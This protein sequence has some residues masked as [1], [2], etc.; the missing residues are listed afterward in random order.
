MSL[1]SGHR[2]TA[3][4]SNTLQL[5]EELIPGTLALHMRPLLDELFAKPF[6][7]TRNPLHSLGRFAPRTT[8]EV[9]RDVAQHRDS[10][11]L[12]VIGG[13]EDEELALVRVQPAALVGGACAVT[14][15]GHAPAL[16]TG[17]VLVQDL[18]HRRDRLSTHTHAHMY[19]H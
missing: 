8:P 3:I 16:Q 19:T 6:E 11:A 2:R 13:D 7:N 4:G 18:R 15:I 12:V 10:G 14:Q 1:S 17:H 5:L 9:L